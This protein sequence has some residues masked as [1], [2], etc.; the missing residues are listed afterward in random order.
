[1]LRRR[2][3]DRE[4]GLRFRRSASIVVKMAMKKMKMKKEMKVRV[5]SFPLLHVYKVSASLT[6]IFFHSGLA[7]RSLSYFVFFFFSLTHFRQCPKGYSFLTRGLGLINPFYFIF[8]K[9]TRDI[10][11]VH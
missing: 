10:K 2:L 5:G 11:L 4:L 9:I 7:F 8:S 3:G 1:M 6:L